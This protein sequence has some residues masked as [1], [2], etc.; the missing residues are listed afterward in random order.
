MQA[1]PER[2]AQLQA[3]SRLFLTLAKERG[4]NTGMSNNTP[5]V[6][7]IT[8]NS[9]HA[10]MLSRAMFE[11]GISVQPILYPAVEEEKARLRFF[12]TSAHTEEQ[13]RHTVDVWP[14]KWPRST[15]GT[16]KV[17]SRWALAR[18]GRCN[19][20]PSPARSN[21]ESDADY[22]IRELKYFRTAIWIGE[23]AKVEGSGPRSFIRSDGVESRD[24]LV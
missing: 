9:L 21:D 5:V 12:I 6:P 4:L 14:K 24:S 11:R 3:N 8:G 20:P 7:I 10:L 15:R 19:L 1:E 16:C 22:Y 13:I 17:V 23:M 2:V 18:A